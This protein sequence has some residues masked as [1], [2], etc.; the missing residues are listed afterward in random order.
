VN[1]EGSAP[2]GALPAPRRSAPKD[3]PPAPRSSAPDGGLLAF[4]WGP[5]WRLL[6]AGLVGAAAEAAGV[7]LI[8]TATWLLM[9][10]AGQP[11]I[12]ALT[13]AIVSVRALAIGRGALRYLERLAGHD[14]VLRIVTE[15]R[16]RIFAHLIDRPLARGADALSRMVSDV[17]AVQ[18]LV[19]RVA[20]PILAGGLICVLG[21]V[22]VIAF[23]PA[24]GLVLSTGLVLTGL[25]MPL[26]GARLVRR[27][28][29]RLAPL[30]AEHAI[31]TVDVIHGAADL[32]AYGATERYEAV[33]AGHADE[34]STLERKLA[35]RS[36][37]LDA[38]SSVLTGL[39]AAGVL[40]VAS[41]ATTRVLAAVLAVATLAMGELTLNL[42][43]AARKG[44]EIATGLR[45]VRPYLESTE[46]SWE[47]PQGSSITLEGISVDGRLVDV[48]LDLPYGKKVAVVGPSGAGKSTLLGV[49]AGF[50]EADQGR[51]VRRGEGVSTGLMADAHLFHT[52][53]AENLRLADPHADDQAVM[54]AALIAGIDV[55]DRYHINVGEN[56]AEFSG[57][58]RQRLA[59]AR[60]LLAD[61]AVLLLDEPTEGLDPAHADE[62]LARVL[63]HAR[64][65]TVVLVT[66]R[67]TG[68]DRLGFDEILVMDRGRIIERDSEGWMRAHLA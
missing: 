59:L 22:T 56:G 29:A 64:D 67:L 38:A 25:L 47:R 19:V 50:V 31:A 54:H 53:V 35:R 5:V 12:T 62:V 34:L 18:D 13:V 32:A 23:D 43:A 37:A 33:A 15:L 60:A 7:A 52:S 65:R 58:E 26:L 8:A 2:K 68:L 42:L 30:R 27:A 17:D 51:V 3:P 11:P 6:G 61:P 66:H 10:A 49:I 28:A 63:D 1:G 36:F 44:A 41:D 4:G 24:A 55:A 46:P 48:D 9:T 40:L 45:R 39:T 57:G 16:A 21:A 20:L 14:A